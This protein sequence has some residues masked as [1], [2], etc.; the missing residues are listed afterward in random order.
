LEIPQNTALTVSGI[1]AVNR[2]KNLNMASYIGFRGSVSINGYTA[3]YVFPINCSAGLM[4]FG[5]TNL[6]NIF[7]YLAGGATST[8]TRPAATLGA[9]VSYSF[10]TNMPANNISL[11]AN[12]TGAKF[13]GNLVDLPRL[14]FYLTLNG[15]SNTEGDIINCPRVTNSLDIGN[16]SKI[17]GIT[18]NI[19]RVDTLLSITNTLIIGNVIELPRVTY[20]LS[21]WGTTIAGNMADIPHP[22]YR[23]YIISCLGISGVYTPLTNLD[24]PSGWNVTLSGMSAA[25]VSNTII[26]CAQPGVVKNNVTFTYTARDATS[27]AAKLDLKTNH[28]WTFV[29]DT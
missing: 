28:A 27:D 17:T 21:V 1:A 16:C 5:W 9:G 2:L 18:S 6:S 19:P 7:W 13:I 29:P 25:D 22:T 12:T 15:C 8:N 10:G 24:T 11:N 4:D 23:L 26:A 20:Y 3:D 14:I